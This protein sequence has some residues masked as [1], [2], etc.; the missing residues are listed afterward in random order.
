MAEAVVMSIGACFGKKKFYFSQW[1]NDLLGQ[2][3]FLQTGEKRK[4][5]YELYALQQKERTIRNKKW[6]EN[7]KKKY[8]KN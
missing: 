2:L 3:Y 5:I 8:L 1:K 4:N 7:L 6:F